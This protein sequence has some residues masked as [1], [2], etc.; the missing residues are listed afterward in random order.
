MKSTDAA[1]RRRASGPAAFVG[2][3][4][5]LVMSTAV[6][7]AFLIV[8]LLV[9]GIAFLIYW[10]WTARTTKAAKPALPPAGQVDADQ[11]EVD[12]PAYRFGTGG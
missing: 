4:S 5:A 3:L 11:A 9:L 7:V 6:F 12:L 10:I 8:P 2:V 1:G